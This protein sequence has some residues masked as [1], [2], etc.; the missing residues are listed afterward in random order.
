[1]TVYRPE[2][3]IRYHDLDE[4]ILQTG[5]EQVGHR[6]RHRRAEEKIPTKQPR[7]FQDALHTQPKYQWASLVS[8]TFL[9]SVGQ[10][11]LA[12]QQYEGWC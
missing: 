8:N 1:M 7:A 12:L 6:D 2:S 5:L 3:A 11:I 9:G 10:A 4:V